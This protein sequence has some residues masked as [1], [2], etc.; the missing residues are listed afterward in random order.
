MTTL[1]RHE[2]SIHIESIDGL[3]ERWSKLAGDLSLESSTSTIAPTDFPSWTT[4]READLEDDQDRLW[5]E[6]I[7]ERFHRYC[8]EEEAEEENHSSSC[9]LSTYSGDSSAETPQREVV[10]LHSSNGSV[11]YKGDDASLSQ[12]DDCDTGS[13]LAGERHQQSSKSNDALMEQEI[14]VMLNHQRAVSDSAIDLKQEEKYLINLNSSMKE[15][16]WDIS[17]ADWY[18][19][20]AEVMSFNA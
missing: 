14:Y 7:R 13:G 10:P 16:L 11:S 4:H 20:G 6:S 9:D 12:H 3:P 17:V 5:F 1:A 15:D 19:E 2:I 18:D 8:I